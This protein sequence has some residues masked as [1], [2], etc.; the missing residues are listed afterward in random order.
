MCTIGACLIPAQHPILLL[1]G[2]VEGPPAKT[3]VQE[4]PAAAPKQTNTGVASEEAVPSSPP[5]LY[6]IKMA[7]LDGVYGAGRGLDASLEMRASVEELLTQIEGLNPQS[8]PAQACPDL[9]DFTACQRL[10]RALVELVFWLAQAMEL[11]HGRWKLVYTTN[12]QAL[13]VL[14]A[15]RG[16]PLVNVGDITQI[17]DGTHLTVENKVE[18]AVPFM[19]SLSAHAAF[20]VKPKLGAGMYPPRLR[21][22]IHSR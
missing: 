4:I 21:R 5:S 22:R 3:P 18:V 2:P 10:C 7:L 14:R 11:L 15:F 12:T 13:A 8:S 9:I 6:L 20:E 19:L 17:I 1:Q 16:L